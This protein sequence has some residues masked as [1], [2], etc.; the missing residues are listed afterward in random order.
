VDCGLNRNG[1]CVFTRR[2]RAAAN[3]NSL[4][5]NSNR[6]TANDNG[7]T[8][9]TPRT[10]TTTDK[11]GCTQIP[12]YLHLSVFICV[13]LWSSHAVLRVFASSRV[14]RV[15]AESLCRLL[16]CAFLGVLAAHLCR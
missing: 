10:A 2:R 12:A 4:T 13:H 6:V 16:L 8:A 15:F 7:F 9:K 11:H 3:D 14:L 1:D 5:A